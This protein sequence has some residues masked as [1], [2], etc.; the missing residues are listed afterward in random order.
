M[1]AIFNRHLS[2]FSTSWQVLTRYWMLAYPLLLFQLVGDW[3]LARILPAAQFQTL[4]SHLLPMLAFSVVWLGLIAAF[5]AGWVGMINNRIE[6]FKR[7]K[8][9]TNKTDTPPV[10]IF[11]RK[12]LNEKLP[13]Q[14]HAFFDSI[15]RFTLPVVGHWVIFLAGA[16]AICWFAH[17]Q[18]ITH[19]GYPDIIATTS[20]WLQANPDATREQ[21]QTMLTQAITNADSELQTQLN[22][23]SQ[24]GSLLILATTLWGLLC[25]FAPSYLWWQEN[26]PTHPLSDKISAPTEAVKPDT[27]KDDA[28]D[29]GVQL[30]WLTSWFGSVKAALT[31]L[32][33]FIPWIIVGYV[34]TLAT[35]LL[36][37]MVVWAS[38]FVW[39]LWLIGQTW[40]AITISVLSGQWA[41]PKPAASLQKPSSAQP[42]RIIIDA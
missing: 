19:G 27:P 34:V 9:A 13:G 24:T 15:G 40:L 20:Q 26:T 41:S 38:P 3:V 30:L 32:V 10:D 31:E 21:L 6:A 29:N 35:T 11:K 25:S 18:I 17:Q 8:S 39:L 16:V 42:S 28:N 22:T 23:F 1:I 5:T 12:R 7:Y 4:D 36:A 37:G 33:A 14:W 2:A